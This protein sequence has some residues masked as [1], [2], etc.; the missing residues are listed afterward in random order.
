MAGNNPPSLTLTDNSTDVMFSID[1]ASTDNDGGIFFVDFYVDNS[2]VESYNPRSTTVQQL[3]SSMYTFKYAPSQNKQY[4]IK[5]IAYDRY[6]SATEKTLQITAQT[7]SNSEHVIDALSVYPNPFHDRVQIIAPVRF[8]ETQI[9][10]FD[11]LGRR[12]KHTS[13]DFSN[14]K[15]L[16]L[17]L[18]KASQAL[19]FMRFT[20]DSH[21]E[22][23]QL[24]QK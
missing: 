15:R 6:G 8:G 5:I 20:T 3:P 12:V 17:T 19:Y 14:K 10:V 16:M 18:P 1:A 24:I 9:E 13:F 21:K 11:L 4:Q 7:L 23:I 2:L 22:I